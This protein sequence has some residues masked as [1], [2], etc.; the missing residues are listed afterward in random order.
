MKLHAMHKS[1]EVEQTVL[2][3]ITFQ[4]NGHQTKET[5]TNTQ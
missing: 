4:A 2:D 3:R 5:K 1:G